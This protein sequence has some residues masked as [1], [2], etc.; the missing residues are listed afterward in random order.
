[1]AVAHGRWRGAVPA[2]VAVAAASATA[3]GRE[4]VGILAVGH[5]AVPLGVVGVVH[6]RWRRSRLA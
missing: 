5:V 2:A 6:G 1:M 3:D 4:G